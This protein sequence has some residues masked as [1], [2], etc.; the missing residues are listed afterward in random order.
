[1][2]LLL[3]SISL[4]FAVTHVLPF[5]KI[6]FKFLVSRCQFL[7]ALKAFIV[8]CLQLYFV[9]NVIEKILKYHKY[10]ILLYVNFPFNILIINQAFVSLV[11][12][13]NHRQIIMI[14]KSGSY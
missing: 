3:F 2:R 4:L 6:F 1:M 8:K 9:F 12:Y 5:L 11:D 7:S 13:L 10:L 14:K